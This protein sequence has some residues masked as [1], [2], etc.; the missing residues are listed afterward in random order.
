MLKM[1]ELEFEKDFKRNF[2]ASKR[3][4]MLNGEQTV[5]TSIAGEGR[6]SDIP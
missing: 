6:I 5:S 2:P 3:H 4:L 1:V